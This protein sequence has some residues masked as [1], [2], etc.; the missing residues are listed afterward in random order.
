MVSMHITLCIA[1]V[2]SVDFAGENGYAEDSPNGTC[3]EPID[4]DQI[5]L[6][7]D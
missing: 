4:W 5:D 7:E 1:G 2:E 3:M 6:A